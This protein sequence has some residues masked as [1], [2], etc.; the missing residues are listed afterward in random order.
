MTGCRSGY[1]P[2]GP[3]HPVVPRMDNMRPE[4][5]LSVS[6]RPST[7]V[8]AAPKL[9]P[10]TREG[11]FSFG[12]LEHAR[13]KEDVDVVGRAMPASVSRGFRRS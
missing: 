10:R 2:A 11:E 13:N 6:T 3:Q 4:Q 1:P 7:E 5:V 9:G 8:A 12:R